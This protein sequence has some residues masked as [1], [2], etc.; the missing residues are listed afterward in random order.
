MG[1]DRRSGREGLPVAVL[2][3]VLAGLV[4]WVLVKVNWEHLASLERRFDKQQ[5]SLEKRFDEQ[6]KAVAAAHTAAMT[7]LQETI[8]VLQL[9]RDALRKER[10]AL[11]RELNRPADEEE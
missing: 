10:N 2:I 6:T 5:E 9:E 7:G 4:V 3:A 8:R 11:R 1:Q